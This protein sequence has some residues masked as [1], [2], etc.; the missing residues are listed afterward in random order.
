MENTNQCNYWHFIYAM[1][2]KFSNWES[3]VQWCVLIL[4]CW[5]IFVIFVYRCIMFYRLM[6]IDSFKNVQEYDIILH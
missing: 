4:D 5:L 6:P 3:M 1:C 2:R